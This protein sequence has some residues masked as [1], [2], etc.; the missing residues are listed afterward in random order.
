MGA[1]ATSTV[2]QAGYDGVA[3]QEWSREVEMVGLPSW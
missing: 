3:E 1:G 2:A